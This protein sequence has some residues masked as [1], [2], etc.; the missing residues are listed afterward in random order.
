LKKI[1]KIIKLVPQKNCEFFDRTKYVPDK[2]ELDIG[3]KIPIPA[4]EKIRILKN[5]LINNSDSQ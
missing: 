3:N 4:E 1:K 5:I 2:D